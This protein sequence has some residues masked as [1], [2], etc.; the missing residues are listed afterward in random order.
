[1]VSGKKMFKTKKQKTKN[2]K[3]IVVFLN[4][5]TKQIYIREPLLVLTKKTTKNNE[6]TFDFL[7]RTN[8]NNKIIFAFLI[9]QN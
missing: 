3:R 7:K 9:K 8:K 4:K 6:R 2:N 1:M 5:K